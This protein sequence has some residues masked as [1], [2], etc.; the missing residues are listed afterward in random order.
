MPESTRPTPKN[1]TPI[2]SEV[3]QHLDPGGV[4]RL[5][6]VVVGTMFVGS[7]VI[8]AIGV[9]Q[10][11]TATKVLGGIGSVA[12]FGIGI[13]LRRG[14]IQGVSVALV[15]VLLLI[16]Q[17]ALLFG[18]G[19]H[20]VAAILLPM[21]M[22]V[23]SLLINV[24]YFGV[25]LGLAIATVSLTAFLELQG[26]VT[27]KFS[28]LYDI[29]DLLVQVVMLFTFG[30]LLRLL[31]NVMGRSLNQATTNRQDYLEIFNT[32]GEAILI[33]DAG[34][35][36]IIDVNDTAL[37]MFALT[38]ED[39][40]TLAVEDISANR[41]PWTGVEAAHFVQQ[42][43]T[44]GQQVFEWLAKRTDGTEF[45]VEVSLRSTVIGGRGRVLAVSRDISERKA[46]QERLQQAEKLES[47]G[48]LAGGIA[49]DFNNQLACII[50]FADLAR[51]DLQDRPEESQHIDTILLAAKRASDL[52]AKLLAF[53]RKG[54]HQSVPVDLNGLVSEVQEIARRSLNPGIRI[55]SG[56]QI[57]PAV[58]LGDPTQL[59][60]AILNLV[61]NARDAM[62]EG[63]AL[64]LAT[65]TIDL[66]RDGEQYPSVTLAPGRY[67][68]L[69]VRDSGVGMTP[70]VMQNIF[71]PFFTTKAAGSGTGM[72]LAAVYGTVHHHGGAIDVESAPGLG[73]TF[74]ILLPQTEGSAATAAQVVDSP[75]RVKIAGTILVVEDDKLVR[76]MIVRTLKS[77]GGT[78]TACADGVE[79]VEVF[80]EAPHRSDLVI[81]DLN[82][83][84]KAG[85]ET[86]KAL[87]RIR[88]EVKV[89]IISGY[90][91]NEQV[92]A[93][94]DEG[95]AGF[96]QKPFRPDALC[97]AV[98]A[99]LSEHD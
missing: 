33:H 47:L 24:R 83:P 18:D 81:L 94:L 89:L 34:T 73:S 65:R 8:L 12:F 87:R 13:A 76:P 64:D 22:V 80:T 60:N 52:T 48:K 66:P 19:I 14:H 26:F 7:L 10:G 71:D 5:L 85:P 11:W 93:L 29:G 95:A 59:Q 45:W 49:H 72:G 54:K 6:R 61:F 74:R 63:G 36:D 92:Q 51:D 77:A 25:I 55:D 20:D 43:M 31:T 2:T 78:V 70:E 38:R 50:G 1:G 46:L 96:L 67:V 42:A 23:G 68:E 84:R 97:G 44:Q 32:T 79:A 86:F 57:T 40:K 37:R 15:G 56:L 27:N 17:G 82:M 98:A 69:S 16:T 41:P 9:I 75:E 88:P 39:I 62:P 35:G 21:I 91:I 53:A 90:A 58:T 99:I 28:E 3:V 4:H 30:L